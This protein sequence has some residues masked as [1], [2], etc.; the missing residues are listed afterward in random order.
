MVTNW[1]LSCFPL[2]I[3]FWFLMLPTD[4]L[5]SYR[6]FVATST[7]LRRVNRLAQPFLVQQRPHRQKS[8]LH[9]GPVHTCECVQMLFAGGPIR[10]FHPQIQ[11]PQKFVC[12]FLLGRTF[13]CFFLA[14]IENRPEQGWKVWGI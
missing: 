8:W 6:F 11:N 5:S 13:V 12:F 10:F 7:L 1:F 4:S 3:C 14:L 2:V 9:R